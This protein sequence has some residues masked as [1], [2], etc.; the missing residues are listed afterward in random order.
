MRLLVPKQGNNKMK[1]QI[2]TAKNGTPTLK[3]NDIYLYSKYYPEKDV[4][5]WAESELDF[6]ASGYVLVGL[7][8]GYHLKALLEKAVNKP[9]AVYYFEPCEYELFLEYNKEQWWDIEQIEIV[10][11]LQ[12][13]HTSENRQLLVPNTWV[14]AIGIN[15]PLHSILEVIKLNTISYKKV[16]KI[17]EKNFTENIKRKD[18]GVKIPSIL[19][20][21]IACLVAAGPSLNETASWLE[22]HQQYVD[23]YV[24]GAALKVLLQQNVKPKA[25]VLSDAGDLTMEQFKNTNFKGE[26]FYLSTANYKSVAMHQGS[27]TVLFQKGY[28]IAEQIANKYNLPLIDTGGS[29]GTT[30]FS[31]LELLGYSTV[32]LFGQ[33]LGFSGVETHAGASPSKK[34]IVHTKLLR[35]IIANDC[36]YIYTTATLQSFL[37]WYNE[38]MKITKM[39]VYNTALKGANIQ[40]ASI[41]DRYQF[42]Q[43]VTKGAFREM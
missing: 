19:P 2:E 40:N 26:L 21:R 4:L 29:V 27:H 22:K 3:V 17:M 8:L 16:A 38:K 18:K 12:L 30:T 31:L 23:I 15:H 9:I 10:H 13:S 1:W 35:K 42:E 20:K 36:S 43:L 24:V 37:Y 28:P 39:K 7:G 41:I 5:K 11:Q 25:V 32:V 14:K 34:E 6:T 33:D